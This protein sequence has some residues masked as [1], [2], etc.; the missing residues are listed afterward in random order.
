MSDDH[1]LILFDGVCNLCNGTVQFIIKR[2]RKNIFRFAS[3]QS[4]VGQQYASKDGA[5]DDLYSILVVKD[6]KVYDRSSAVLE[7]ARHLTVPWRWFSV[8]RFVPR[9]IR[10]AVYSMVSANRYRMFG[11]RDQCMIPTPE[12][13]SKFLD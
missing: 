1:I 9:V 11:K 13:K 3:L 4:S 10:D 7:I 8:F 12:L 2:D 6:G 5:G